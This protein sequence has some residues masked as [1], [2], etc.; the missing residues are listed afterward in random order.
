MSYK[1]CKIDVK[2]KKPA[3]V[4]AGKTAAQITMSKNVKKA[5]L[6]KLEEQKKKYKNEV[7]TFVDIQ[8]AQLNLMWYVQGAMENYTIC[9][10]TFNRI[11][12]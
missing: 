8:P 4:G 11:F 1:V 7:P 5:I 2:T 3:K 6:C 12:F 10:Q 9:E